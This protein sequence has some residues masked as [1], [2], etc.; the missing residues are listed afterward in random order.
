MNK[1]GDVSVIKR[2]MSFVLTFL[3]FSSC[4][5]GKVF[6]SATDENTYDLLL[7]DAAYIRN[8]TSERTEA[9]GGNTL[10]IQN[11]SG[12]NNNRMAF[13]KF[14]FSEHIDSIDDIDEVKLAL[15]LKSNITGVDYTVSIMPDSMEEWTSATLTYAFAEEAG[16]TDSSNGELLYTGSDLATEEYAFSDNLADAVKNHLKQNTDNMIVTFRIFSTLST[17]YTLY[18]SKDSTTAPYI[19]IH[20]TVN[21]KAIV[22]EFCSTITFDKINSDDKSAVKSHFDLITTGPRGTTV[23]WTSSDEKTVNPKTGVV[24]QPKLGEGNKTVT[25]TAHVTNGDYSKDTEPFEFVV[26]ESQVLPDNL[27]SEKVVYTTDSVYIR[28]GDKYKDTVY[29]ATDIVLD[30]KTIAAVHR[31]G[32]VR[33]DFTGLEE[34]LDTVNSIE[35][36]ITTKNVPDG[37]NSE[38]RVYVLPETMEDINPSNL[39]YSVAE[40]KGLIGYSED[41]TYSQSGLNGNTTYRTTNILDEIK[42]NLEDADNKIVWLKISSTAGTAYTMYGSNA[43]EDLKPAMI[44]KYTAPHAELDL[45]LIDMPKVTDSDIILPTVGKF[46]SSISWQTSNLDLITTDGTVT[47][48]TADE[49]YSKEDSIITLTA[50][51]DNNGDI[52][53]KKYTIRLRRKGVIDATEDTFVTEEG[54]FFDSEMLS[55]GGKSEAVPI[56]SFDVSEYSEL[57]NGSRKIVLKL[58]SAEDCEGMNTTV[59]PITESAAKSENLEQLTYSEATELLQETQY[60]SYEEFKNASWITF[61][62]TD[63]M[64][65]LSDGKAVFALKTKGPLL[66]VISKNG[67]LNYEPKLIVSPI[68]YTEEYAAERAAELLDYDDFTTES[69]D[70]IRKNLSLPDSGRFQSSITWSSDNESVLNPQTGA[71]VRGDIDIPIILTAHIKVGETTIDKPFPLTVIKA[72]T[73]AEY[74]EYLLSTLAPEN[75][76]LTTSIPLAGESTPDAVVSWQSSEP[77]EAKVDGYK[78]IVTRPDGIDLPVELTATVEINSQEYKKS[79]LVTVVRSGDDNILWNRKISQGDLTAKNAID[80][81]IE[82]VWNIRN[83]VLVLDLGTEKLISKLSLVPTTN[84]FDDISVSVSSDMYEWKKSFSGGNFNLGELNYI[85]LSPIAFGRYIKL[86]FPSAASAVSFLAAYSYSENNG[87]EE[88]VFS[89]VSVPG[90]VT[91]DFTLPSA[92][93]GNTISWSS[94]S[95]VIVLNGSNAT[96]NIPTYG[97]NVTLTASVTVNGTPHTKSYVIYVQGSGNGG[98]NG[99]G[100]GGSGK[101]SSGTIIASP[102]SSSKSP[103]VTETTSRFNDLGSASWAVNYI[104]YLAD[105]GIVNGKTSNSFAPQDF[106]RR[107]EMAKILTLAFDISLDNGNVGFTDVVSGEWYDKYVSA[108]VHSGITQGIGNDEFGIGLDITRQD[109]FTMIASVL[110]T[111]TS[112]YIEEDTS[113]TDYTA[114]SDYARPSILALKELGIVSGDLNGNV[115]PNAKITRAEIAKVICLAMEVYSK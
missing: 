10:V 95:D 45:Q 15:S 33:F 46:G 88:D 110:G 9:L 76:L 93:Y 44:I 71:I 70:S 29:K 3:I 62:V 94:S 109:A 1:K 36:S 74:A 17:A 66:S 115:N 34:Y 111:D 8:T 96:V 91:D 52:F 67:T 16:M 30:Y 83:K 4:F 90:E 32:F 97:K 27:V 38:F 69:A 64:Y 86:E 54:S 103:D 101:P 73:D 24:T 12:E 114:I 40:E 63:Y 92:I 13:L 112:E 105:K 65:S 23:A 39:S 108:L 85:N 81:D 41:F 42:Q 48:V 7:S 11:A 57:I 79:F 56:I 104:N 113:F 100:S 43:A 37:E 78:L 77:Y 59:I 14:D 53:K 89:S 26:P 58:Y 82:T 80:E 31:M 55:F 47:V 35:F 25:L 50:T 84:S 22:D 2:Y 72:E 49:D 61:D 99:S 6:V 87:V 20:K 28:N 18:G 68:A 21:F 51:S 106:L 60:A 5:Y 19:T 98:G 102:P 75:T 107:E